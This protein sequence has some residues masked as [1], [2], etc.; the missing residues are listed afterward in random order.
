MSRITQTLDPPSL[1]PR[2][3]ASPGMS[4][5]E[6]LEDVL[7]LAGAAASAEAR[8][9]DDQERDLRYH[10]RELEAIDAGD[11]RLAAAAARSRVIDEIESGRISPSDDIEAQVASLAPPPS[12]T[13]RAFQ[14]GYRDAF[15]E[16]VRRAL[17]GAR[18][19]AIRRGVESLRPGL[20]ANIYAGDD[21][22]AQIDAYRAANPEISEA[23]SIDHL[24][25]PAL[26]EAAE[27]GNRERVESIRAFAAG[28]PQGRRLEIDL[29][30]AGAIVS[31]SEHQART[32]R[33]DA[34]IES[35]HRRLN[36]GAP[37]T[38]AITAIDRLGASGD[39]D[40][41]DVALLRETVLSRTK[42]QGRQRIQADILNGRLVGED[43]AAEIRR[44]IDLPLDHPLSLDAGTG[45]TLLAGLAA[46]EQFDLD[47]AQVDRVI[48]GQG[49]VL[50]EGQ[51]GSAFTARIRENGII[52]GSNTV[53]DPDALADL[54]LRARILPSDLRQ[55]LVQGLTGTDAQAAARSARAIGLIS[56]NERLRA[57]LLD[58]AGGDAGLRSQIDRA[59]EEFEN[60]RGGEAAVAAIRR[61]GEAA[62]ESPGPD[63]AAA[64]RINRR[65]SDALEQAADRAI[66]RYR[67]KLDHTRN[68]GGLFFGAFNP[69][70]VESDDL[71]SQS[72]RWLAERY[73]QLPPTI[74]ESRRIQIAE[75]YAQAQ[76]ENRFDLVRWGGSVFPVRI[77][78]DDGVAL[79]EPMRWGPGFEDE[80][81]KDLRDAGL[82]PAAIAGLSPHLDASRPSE[83]G[84]FF[85]DANG[86]PLVDESGKYLVWTPSD[87][88]QAANQTYRAELSR[89]A[90]MFDH[91]GVIEESDLYNAWFQS[92]DDNR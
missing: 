12:E 19:G 2:P 68:A 28:H 63:R 85:L 14:R 37:Y 51:H 8:L 34:A 15:D 32:R 18:Q 42:D 35:V 47:R 1:T 45:R 79:P 60:G 23:D 91:R 89:R 92:L 56:T 65:Q 72:R 44:R 50:T 59:V 55:T 16:P 39:L 71:E 90:E 25:A 81:R 74:P 83:F 29:D 61:A 62:R 11:G 66:E 64:E 43:A 27:S 73:A 30:E 7:G 31:A 40:Q 6:Q 54:V 4:A 67:A 20:V 82:D 57:K 24:V 17:Y 88:A 76:A 58:D 86:D 3:L 87:R 46:R 21:I 70:L 36:D 26:R 33:R 22:Q 77:H 48:D 5:F 41:Q 75:R 53:A 38:E 80:A 10:R 49:A 13:S 69:V 78:R 52:D 9:I 84:W